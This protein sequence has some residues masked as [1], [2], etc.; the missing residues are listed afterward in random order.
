MD[1]AIAGHFNAHTEY[2]ESFGNGTWNDLTPNQA[3]KRNDVIIAM[4][5]YAALERSNGRPV[6]LETA[7]NFA[8]QMVA[9]E[10][11]IQAAVAKTKKEIADYN[12]HKTNKPTSTPA[13][14]GKKTF[15]ETLETMAKDFDHPM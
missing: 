8:I 11:K 15:K 6:V 5:Q 3:G 2:K 1:A 7:F 13:K 14:G 10:V 9:P 4:D 12:Q